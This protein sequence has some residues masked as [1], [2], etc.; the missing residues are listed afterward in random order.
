MPLFTIFGVASGFF[1]YGLLL[2]LLRVVP[3]VHSIITRLL[4]Y[5]ALAS[6]LVFLFQVAVRS[7]GAGVTW[8]YQEAVTFAVTVSSSLGVAAAA[9]SA[10][11]RDATRSNKRLERP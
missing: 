5:G 7:L 3:S 4:R 9:F 8:P 2:M 1:T 6:L 10:F 11:N